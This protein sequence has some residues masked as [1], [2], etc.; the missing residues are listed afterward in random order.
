VSLYVNAGFANNPRW[1]WESVALYEN[2]ELVDPRSLDYMVRGTPPTLA[3]LNADVTQGRQVYEV[4][5]LLGEFVV[6]SWGRDGLLR[7]IRANGDT[8]SALGLSSS[9]F[10]EAWFAFVRERYF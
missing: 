3:Q 2:G 10:E 9:A 4:G 6:A 5:Y 1:L 7:L 8:S